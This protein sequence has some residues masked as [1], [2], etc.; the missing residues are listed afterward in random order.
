M[1]TRVLDDTLPVEADAGAATTADRLRS[2]ALGVS[3]AAMVLVPTLGPIIAGTQEGAQ[4]LDTEITP[5]NY[6]FT[7]WA[8][9]F[10]AVAGNAI[11]HAINPTAGINRR[12]GWW[13]TGAYSANSV[14]SI[15]AQ[16]GRF[17]YTPFILPVAA[18]LAGVAHRKTQHSKPDRWQ[19]LATHS[20]GLLLGWTGVA[21]VVNVFAT[22]RHGRLAPTTQTGKATAQSA[23][24]G[25]AA[26]LSV[27]I[28]TAR[29]GYT[30]IASAGAWALVT[31][32]ANPERT[33][34]T[35][36]IGATGATLIAGTTTAKLWKHEKRARPPGFA[37]PAS[38]QDDHS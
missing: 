34:R 11:Q 25:A 16:S 3:A 14:W 26:T 36:L 7:I 21:A 18:T 33:S 6:A 29:H 19:N 32:A 2:A 20:T 35:R 1:S 13:L 17:R 12:T 31:N 30:S 27:V 24:A 4:E 28:A 9:I 5:P 15:A 23:V 22:R 38:G 37:S 8:P 10:A